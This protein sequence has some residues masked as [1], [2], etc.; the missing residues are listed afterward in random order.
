[1]RFGASLE[2]LAPRVLEGGRAELAAVLADVAAALR[3]CGLD[4][5]EFPLDALLVYP[6]ILTPDAL[7]LIRSHADA[8][9]FGFGAH[10]PYMWLDLAALNED[11]RRAS[12]SAVVGAA[13]L[14]R[15]L[16]PAHYT[17]HPVGERLG[18]LARSAWTQR[19]RD[20]FRGRMLERSRR[21]LE[22]IAAAIGRDRLYVEN[23]ESLPAEVAFD[24]AVDAGLGLC[25]DTGHALLQGEDPAH[26]LARH[27]DRVGVVHLHD[28]RREGGALCDHRPLG[29]GI[30][31]LSTLRRAL[32]EA[33]FQG[34]MVL[35]MNDLSD[36]RAS[37][38]A[39]RVF[40]QRRQS[41]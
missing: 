30:L 41:R 15:P 35:E 5:V 23:L 20:Y 27:G 31:D 39:L 19:E 37:V 2:S 9:G 4:L 36:T 3:A 40:R 32:E 6:A 38:Q 11:I 17:L 34:T 7:A 8:H 21:S 13:E 14:A 22:E 33:R 26:L 16:A 25:L 18:S 12:V 29:S 1:M 24:V 10:L 28:V